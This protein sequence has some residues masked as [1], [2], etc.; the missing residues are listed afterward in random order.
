[1]A[2]AVGAMGTATI[3]STVTG[4][5]SRPYVQVTGQTGLCT[6]TGFVQ[7]TARHPGA[8]DAFGTIGLTTTKDSNDTFVVYADRQLPA[9][10]EIVFD[11]VI[12]THTA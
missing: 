6:A 12:T 7:V 2:E 5:G 3:S 10:K 1:M 8:Q 11:W 9:G 4:P